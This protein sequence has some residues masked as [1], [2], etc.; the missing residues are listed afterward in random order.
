MN[1]TEVFTDQHTSWIEEKIQSLE[2][3]VEAEWGEV[4]D[5]LFSHRDELT[6]PEKKPR[7]SAG[8]RWKQS[9]VRTNPRVVSALGDGGDLKQLGDGVDIRV[10]GVDDS[11]PG[12]RFGFRTMGNLD[13]CVESM[14]NSMLA[15][16][17]AYEIIYSADGRSAS[18]GCLDAADEAAR[19]VEASRPGSVFNTA[20]EEIRDLLVDAYVSRGAR[21]GLVESAGSRLAIMATDPA[22]NLIMVDPYSR[23]VTRCSWE[24]YDGQVN[25]PDHLG[26]VSKAEW[27][28]LVMC[29]SAMQLRDH[30]VR[31]CPCV[32]KCLESAWSIGSTPDLI[33]EVADIGDLHSGHRTKKSLA[34]LA[35]MAVCT[36]GVI[37]LTVG[38]FKSG[39]FRNTLNLTDT[40][41]YASSAYLLLVGYTLCE[42]ARQILMPS[43]SYG[44]A[45]RGDTPYTKITETIYRDYIERGALRLLIFSSKVVSV[46]SSYNSC[47]FAENAS[48]H[49][50]NDVMIDGKQLIQAGVLCT[51]EWSAVPGRDGVTRYAVSHGLSSIYHMTRRVSNINHVARVLEKHDFVGAGARRMPRRGREGSLLGSI[52]PEDGVDTI[53]DDVPRYAE[54]MPVL[55]AVTV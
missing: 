10:Y 53:Q 41:M 8:R 13:I 47:V 29:K 3:A 52:Q 28:N 36:T 38:V 33:K 22:T 25:T 2:L 18:L 9:V 55:D 32:T 24:F 5:S 23:M 11:P 43:S 31:S 4:A 21:R 50:D 16:R 49:I 46:F 26:P 19:K 6:G 27:Q 17:L 7:E 37:G 15:S 30:G 14:L 34:L 45:V 1:L 44:E 40:E 20:C 12:T 35:I 39:S 51:N 48:G 42:V 54:R